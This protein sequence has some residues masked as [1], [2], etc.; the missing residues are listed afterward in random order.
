[1]SKR[2]ERIKILFQLMEW[3]YI[4]D[5]QH[6]LLESFESQFEKRGDLSDKQLEIMES[7]NQQANDRDRPFRR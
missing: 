2:F 4:T 1:M 5:D 7:I 6:R 3:D